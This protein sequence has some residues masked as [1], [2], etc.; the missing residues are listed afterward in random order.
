M[1]LTRRFVLG[2]QNNSVLLGSTR[3]TATELLSRVGLWWSTLSDFQMDWSALRH[4]PEGQEVIIAAVPGTH[5]ITRKDLLCYTV[6]E[7]ADL[8]GQDAPRWFMETMVATPASVASADKQWQAIASAL[9]SRGGAHGTFKAQSRR[10]DAGNRGKKM[11]RRRQC[12]LELSKG[13]RI[14]LIQP[15]ISDEC[16]L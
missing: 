14:V 15:H 9:V 13:D 11:R 16:F 6:R 8:I 4:L 5:C 10:R 1:P 3:M 12:N 2:H 7:Y